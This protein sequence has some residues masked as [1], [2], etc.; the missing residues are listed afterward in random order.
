MK[1]EYYAR[2]RL[3]YLIVLS[4]LLFFLHAPEIVAVVTAMQ[5]LLFVA[6]K[7]PFSTLLRACKRLVLLCV[8]VLVSYLLVPLGENFEGTPFKVGP[9]ELKVYFEGLPIAIVMILRILALITVSIWARETSSAEG[10]IAA[11]RWLRLP[12]SVAVAIDAGLHLSSRKKHKKG[13]RSGSGS[14]GGGGR[15]RKR[16]EGAAGDEGAN[17]SYREIRQ[18][19]MGFMESLLH[20]AHIQAKNFL[21]QNYPN[22]KPEI[23]HDTAVIVTIVVAAMSLKLLQ[24]LP[25]LP[26][27][28]GHKNLVVVPLLAIAVLTTRGRWGGFQAGL[29]IGVASFMLGYGKFGLL[30]VAHFALPGLV[31]DLIAPSLVGRAGRTLWLRFA[32]FGAV[33]GVTRFAANFLIIM[34]AGAPLLAWV[35]FMPML[36]SQTLFG[37]LSAPIGLFVVQKITR[38]GLFAESVDLDS[39]S[40]SQSEEK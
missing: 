40:L 13:S 24:L 39:P 3:I 35:V 1:T 38:G 27:A 18:G 2:A 14:G 6:S 31:A 36:V 4:S 21:T 10:F 32:L 28:P 12:E 16:Q 26:I 37:A 25:G 5:V 22:L 29:A 20:R 17:I 23:I 34:L 11:L 8:I 15:H 7:A 9:V 33:I 19:R 30:E